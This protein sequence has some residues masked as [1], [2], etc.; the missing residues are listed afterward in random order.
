MKSAKICRGKQNEFDD[1]VIGNFARYAIPQGDIELYVEAKREARKTLFEMIS[2]ALK[3]KMNE[4][5]D[6]DFEVGPRDS[7]LSVMRLSL[8]DGTEITIPLVD[9]SA[10][11]EE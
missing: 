4:I 8:V 6:L 5:S 10:T 3:I 11:K 9:K 1:P 2:E 7:R